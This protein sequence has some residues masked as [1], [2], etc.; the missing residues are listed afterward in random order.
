MITDARVLRDQFT[1]REVVHRDAEIQQL[2]DNLEPIIDSGQAQ[3][4]LVHG[5]TGVGKT[6][7]TQHTLDKLQEE[8]LEVQW[9][10]INCWENYN[11][12]RVL[13]K[14][15][16]GIG[17]TLDV[18]RQSTPTDEL[19]TRLREYDKRP[20]ILILDE[21]DQVE[22]T[23][24]L[25]DLYSLEHVTLIM[26]ANREEN[27][28]YNM[29]DRVR[30][31]LI[32]SDRV[33]FNAYSHQALTDILSDRADW[34]L[35][36]DAVSAEQLEQIATAADGDARVAIGILRNAA[37]K[38]DDTGADTITDEM[39]TE[40]VPHAEQEIRQKS[41][42]KLSDHQKILYDIISD[43]DTIQPRDLYDAYEEEV[44]DPRSERMLRKYLN[45]MEH[46]N[47]INAEG[48]GRWRQYTAVEAG[49]ST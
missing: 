6:C 18:H 8:A 33:R 46:Y 19:L 39:I 43:Q 26:I 27:V 34:G 2:A 4:M 20:Y 41:V 1:P 24:V 10:Y 16:E 47:L 48:D 23:E 17:Q 49:N 45:K 3:N 32:N 9:Q 44:D 29:D 21:V 15:L 35:H 30:S 12:F 38:A 28:F 14:A 11:R 42:D 5:P 25:Y 40:A 31:R 13:Y 7:I 22:D 37:R 36:P